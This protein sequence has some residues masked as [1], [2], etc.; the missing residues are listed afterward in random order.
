MILPL[1]AISVAA[2]TAAVW[3]F[4]RPAE[5]PVQAV[6]SVAAYPHDA[7]AF[8]QGLVIR[9]GTLYESTGLYGQSSVRQVDLKTG[10]AKKLAPLDERIFGEGCTVLGGELFLVTWQEKTGYVFDAEDL[11][12]KRA[13]RYSGEGWGL[14][15]DGKNLIL[16]DGTAVLR[17]LDPKDAKVVKRL[18][19]RDAGHPVEKL[20]E[21]EYID[22]E[23]YANVW[24]SDRIA[25]ISAQTGEVVGW[26]DAS[27]LRR[28]LPLANPREDV[29]NGIAYDRDAKKLYLTGKRW[30]RLFEVEVAK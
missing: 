28:G 25:R 23:I 24:Y 19:V 21:L 10:V 7:D 27:A 2:A 22:G 8:T 6:R 16:S 1:A 9:G 3:A 5:T 29:L 11:T 18:P 12:Y 15:D 13:F 17:F 26:L 30:P 14:T 4:S 20:N